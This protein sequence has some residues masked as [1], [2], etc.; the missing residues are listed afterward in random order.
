MKSPRRSKTAAGEG[1]LR[2]HAEL[3]EGDANRDKQI[4]V[5]A[6]RGL[7][8]QLEQHRDCAAETLLAWLQQTTQAGLAAS[9]MP[10]Y[11][12]DLERVLML[13][14]AKRRSRRGPCTCSTDTGRSPSGRHPD[15]RRRRRRQADKKGA[16]G[17]GTAGSEGTRAP[18]RCGSPFCTIRHRRRRRP[19]RRTRS[20]MCPKEPAPGPPGPAD[21]CIP[22]KAAA[23]WPPRQPTKASFAF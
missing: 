7:H 19:R 10:A 17:R 3:V 12:A 15:R 18:C 14:T 16:W 5:I 6:H 2:L 8:A 13:H 4:Q 11:P 23:G 21:C 9:N 1:C 22:R 20:Q